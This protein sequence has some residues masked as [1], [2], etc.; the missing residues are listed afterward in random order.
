MNPKKT[1]RQYIKKVRK[2]F[3]EGLLFALNRSLS[4]PSRRRF[5]P[6][7]NKHCDYR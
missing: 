5:F 3:S 1:I 7:N 2:E 4:S 6:T